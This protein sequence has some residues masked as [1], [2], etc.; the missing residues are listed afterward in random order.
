[1]Q[2]VSSKSGYLNNTYNFGNRKKCLKK[3]LFNLKRKKIY[4]NV[5][6]DVSYT[7]KYSKKKI[8]NLRFLNSDLK[9]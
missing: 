6:N 9:D 3:K 7:L 5:C 1:M 2:S 4:I 8:K